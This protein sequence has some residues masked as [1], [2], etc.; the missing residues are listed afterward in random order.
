MS[1][2]V[3]RTR[4]GLTRRTVL[5]NAQIKALPTT[6]IE[7]VPA[8]GAGRTIIP[9]L[10][11][12]EL[13]WIANYATID[14]NSVLS[15]S[16]GL[17][18]TDFPLLPAFENPDSS[19]TALLAIGS[20]QIALACA[21]SYNDSGGVLNMFVGFNK[22]NTVNAGLFLAINNGASGDLTGGDPGNS[23]IVNVFYNV[24]VLG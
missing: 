2:P 5:T 6:G 7:V 14:V 17:G 8:P 9:I 16:F 15:I 11:A 4:F 23:M 13:V 18:G 19:V 22:L 10:A 20:G 24:I 3:T 12:L 21:P 1:N